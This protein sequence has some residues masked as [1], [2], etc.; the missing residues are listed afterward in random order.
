MLNG[1]IQAAIG[2]K[3]YYLPADLKVL[4]EYLSIGEQDNRLALLVCA[5]RAVEELSQQTETEIAL[6]Q[7]GAQEMGQDPSTQSLER[8]VMINRVFLH[9]WKKERKKAETIG[10]LSSITAAEI[11]TVLHRAKGMHVLPDA[12]AALLEQD[13]FSIVTNT[14]RTMQVGDLVSAGVVLLARNKEGHEREIRLLQD[15][16]VYIHAQVSGDLAACKKEE[17]LLTEKVQAVIERQSTLA[18]V[19]LRLRVAKSNVGRNQLKQAS[20]APAVEQQATPQTLSDHH[21]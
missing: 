11:A 14:T 5:Q 4:E 7:F 18:G 12:L 1:I 3:E 9:L 15:G 20:T 8:A 2:N 17:T 13:G 16:Q 21:S 6:T 19:P 10:Q